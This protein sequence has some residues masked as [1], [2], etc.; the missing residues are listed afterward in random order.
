MEHTDTFLKTLEGEEIFFGEIEAVAQRW[1]RENMFY[2]YLQRPRPN[3]G[4][5]FLSAEFQAN[6][7]LPT[8]AEL[9]AGTGSIIFLPEGI[10]YDVH[11]S[12]DP[13]KNAGPHSYVINFLPRALNGRAVDFGNRPLLLKEKG[14]VTE[15]VPIL[16]LCRICHEIPRQQVRMQS[17]FFQIL[18]GILSSVKEQKDNAYAIRKGITLLQR[19]CFANEKISKYAAIC[20]MSES[21]FRARFKEWAGMSPVEYRN[22]Q[23]ISYACGFLRNTSNQI[24]EIARQVGFDD[25]FYFSRVFQQVTGLSPSDY[26]KK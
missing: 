18:D 13:E 11:F 26:R 20:G 7:R 25:A 14:F 17:L 19:E 10:H 3:A 1:T 2:S 21:Y 9:H 22:R 8:G 6:F 12:G 16:E 23:R 4:F 24:N 15:Q 5:F